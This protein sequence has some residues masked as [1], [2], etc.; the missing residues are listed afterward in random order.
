MAGY[1]SCVS[2]YDTQPHIRVYTSNGSKVTEQ[3][4]DGKWY[5]GAFSADGAT[6]GS[7]SWVD[8]NRQIHIRVY[9]ANSAGKITEYCW[10]K[11]KWYVGGFSA[12][13]TG[14]EATC[15]VVNGQVY[16]RVYVR[17]ADGKFT[18]QCWDGKG[19]YKGGYPG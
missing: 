8:G 11:D 7:T 12:A 2:W 17:G 5:T 6:V 15:W 13:G 9:V 16:I 3:A 18:E 19:W 1:V 14:C 4:Y 10:D